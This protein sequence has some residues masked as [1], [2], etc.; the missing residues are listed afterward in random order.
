[1]MGKPLRQSKNEINGMIERTKK[2][3]EL[4]PS[5]LAD[6]ILPYKRNFKRVIVREPVGTVLIVNLILIL[7]I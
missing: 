6:E 3:I 4:A 5:T 7:L 2:M 1:M